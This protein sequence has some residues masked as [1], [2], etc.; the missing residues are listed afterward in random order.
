VGDYGVR[1]GFAMAWGLPA[2]PPPAELL[3]HGDAFRPYRSVVAWYCWQVVDN[4]T[5]VP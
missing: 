3:E 5:G 2:V 1:A 4:P